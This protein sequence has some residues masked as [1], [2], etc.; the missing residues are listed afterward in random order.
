MV[1]QAMIILSQAVLVGCLGWM[2]GSLMLYYAGRFTRDS[3]SARSLGKSNRMRFWTVEI[4][5][6][7]A[8]LWLWFN[9]V[10]PLNFVNDLVL[11][12]YFGIVWVVDQETRLI[13]YTISASGLVIGLVAGGFRNGIITTLVGGVVGFSLSLGL[14]LF[15]IVFIA[16]SNRWRG[17]STQE[18]AFGFGDVL[19]GGVIGL[20]VGWPLI[21]NSLLISV[22]L[23]GLF[24]LLYLGLKVITRSYTFGLAI[25][26]APF[27][28]LGA[29]VVLY[30]QPVLAGS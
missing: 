8:L 17:K 22:L 3:A 7:L 12:F 16:I 19:L 29:L 5:Y 30:I 6:A 10:S 1:S 11:L 23:A 14:F 13:P 26:Y 15:G 28:I 27:L 21:V 20:V 4:I 24:S 2:A 18:V 9:R 25:P